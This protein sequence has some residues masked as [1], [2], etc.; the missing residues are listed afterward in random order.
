[1]YILN[2]HKMKI[3]MIMHSQL[4]IATLL[5][6]GAHAHSEGYCSCLVCMCV[7]VCVCVH[8][9]VCV[10]IDKRYRGIGNAK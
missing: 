7:C 1:M 10:T 3:Y 8:V 2:T 6:L 5:T 9:C 4:Y